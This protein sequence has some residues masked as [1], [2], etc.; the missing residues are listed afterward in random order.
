MR[1]RKFVVGLECRKLLE[2]AV[3]KQT[4]MTITRRVDDTWQVF[5]AQ[6]LRMQGNLMLF[7]QPVP[8]DPSAHLE[9][10][11]GQVVS[12]A[13][14]KG[15]NKCLFNTRV[16]GQEQYEW[17]DGQTVPAMKVFIPQQIEKI[18]RRTY[19]R[20]PA[21][22]GAPVIV[23]FWRNEKDRWQGKLYNLSAGGIGLTMPVDSVPELVENEQLSISFV[24]LENQG[25]IEAIVRFRHV[26]ECPD[27]G[28][29]HIGLQLM[30]L[31]ASEEGRQLVRRI[32]RI[33]SV[34]ERM[35]TGIRHPSRA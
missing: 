25:S 16:V 5:K 9:L 3:L 21:P 6:F 26:E 29:A 35:S 31:E 18:Q 33:V 10:T 2:Q 1:N 24:P 27:T 12:V 34:Y 19:N 23:D 15:Y 28:S 14:K 17:E 32:G 7:S 20:A 8:D 22:S 13:F 30:G 4:P 11:P